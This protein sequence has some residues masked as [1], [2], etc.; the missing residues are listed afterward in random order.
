MKNAQ[1]SYRETYGGVVRQIVIG[2]RFRKPREESKRWG[3]PLEQTVSD[4]SVLHGPLEVAALA[5]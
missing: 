4:L 1:E 3:F 2:K 5:V